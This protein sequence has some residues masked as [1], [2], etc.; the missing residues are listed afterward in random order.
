[1]IVPIH[2]AG[3]PAVDRIAA[4][5]ALDTHQANTLAVQ[6]ESGVAY[7]KLADSKDCFEAVTIG[8]GSFQAV[9]IRMIEMPQFGLRQSSLDL[10]LCCLASIDRD[11]TGSGTCKP[12]RP[13][14][15]SMRRRGRFCENFGRRGL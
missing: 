5:H 10:N 3:E 2:S 4:A 9:K 6:V 14:P 7:F 13:V 15:S 12:S 11:A 8:N 1:M